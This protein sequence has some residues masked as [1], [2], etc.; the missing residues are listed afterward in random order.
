M[1][2]V[3]IGEPVQRAASWEAAPERSDE[4]GIEQVP[5]GFEYARHL[6]E[7]ALPL[8]DVVGCLVRVDEVELVIGERKRGGVG[9]EEA[10]G[11]V[12]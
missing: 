8:G 5:V 11:R 2:P 6:R 7:R 12:P 10:N 1:Q 4:I 3:L 9:H